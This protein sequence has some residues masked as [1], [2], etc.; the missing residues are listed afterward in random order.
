MI[1]EGVMVRPLESLAWVLLMTS[2]LRFTGVFVFG[3]GVGL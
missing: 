1:G 3:E 2:T